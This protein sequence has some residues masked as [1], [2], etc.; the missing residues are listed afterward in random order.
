MK[1]VILAEAEESI[2]SKLQAE[3]YGP[4]YSTYFVQRSFIPLTAQV[5]D[6]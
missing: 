6:I 2:S 3:L 1:Y 5:L 4:R